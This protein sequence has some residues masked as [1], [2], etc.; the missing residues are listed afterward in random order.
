M[1]DVRDY[2]PRN[3]RPGELREIQFEM[4]FFDAIENGTKT[5]TARLEP[6]AN[7]GEVVLI[8]GRKYII[9]ERRIYPFVRLVQ[10]TYRD[11]GFT[12]PE[13]F[14]GVLFRIYGTEVYGSHL[15]S[16]K[17][18]PYKGEISDQ[19][20]A[21]G[22]DSCFGCGRGNL[23]TIPTSWGGE[24]YCRHGNRLVGSWCNAQKKVDMPKRCSMH[25]ELK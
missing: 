25:G 6:K 9:T 19:I 17:F 4:K 24:F 21:N 18:A 22:R 3:E 10:E 11:E 20:K 23:Y 16:H 1:M 13:E 15:Y 2:I 5:R 12:S 7:A 8:F 14:S